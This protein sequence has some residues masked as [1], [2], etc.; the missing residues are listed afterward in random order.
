MR[1]DRFQ[2][3]EREV[4]FLAYK[5]VEFVGELRGEYL[6]I[7]ERDVLF[8]KIIHRRAYDLALKGT[9]FLADIAEKLRCLG[10]KRTVDEDR[11][12]ADFNLPGRRSCG[13]LVLYRV[14]ILDALLHVCLRQVFV[15][16][17]GV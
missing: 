6:V 15:S 12:P 13:K 2:L 10:E 17:L 4:V 1:Q 11:L 7:Q 9:Y 14:Q 3:I 16:V 8:D 5:L